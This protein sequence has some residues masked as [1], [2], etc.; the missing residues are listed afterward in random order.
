MTE[1]IYVG[2]IGTQLRTTLNEDLTGYS[3]IQY[4]IQKPSGTIVTKTCS[5]EDVLNGIVY[6]N[7]IDGDLD[8]V[9]F[10]KIQTD[11]NFANGN[12][13]ES[14]TQTFYVEKKFN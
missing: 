5:V 4:K 1:K 13:N 12:H 2:D 14:V 10:Y 11:I 6:Y 7:T 3:L 8:E 9:G